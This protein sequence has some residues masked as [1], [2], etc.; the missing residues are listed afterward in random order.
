MELSLPVAISLHLVNHHCA[1]FAPMASDIPLSVAFHIQAPNCSPTLYCL[2]PNARIDFFTSP[3]HV[4]W[5]PDV[6]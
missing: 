6:D 1:V 3:R 2:L 5:K 4:T